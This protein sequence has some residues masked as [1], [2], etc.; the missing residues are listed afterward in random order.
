MFH[1]FIPLLT[2]G[3]GLACLPTA[4]AQTSLPLVGITAQRAAEAP[5]PR[6][7][8]SHV[9]PGYG[10]VLREHLSVLSVDRPTDM[11]VRFRLDEGA[12]G[13]I[14]L[15][16]A[17]MEMRNRIRRAMYDLKCTGD[18]QANQQFA[19]LLR[20]IPEGDEGADR[21]ALRPE[22]EVLAALQAAD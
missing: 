21:L 4:H 12:V 16:H 14:G 8:V 1:R 15:R 17:P 5:A 3:A 7:D 22:S 18:G 10:E 11:I 2:L 13:Q 9:C 6:V 20:V 19:F